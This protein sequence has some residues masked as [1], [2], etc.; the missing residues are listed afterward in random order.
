MK[1]RILIG[2]ALALV[3]IVVGWFE[4]FSQPESHRIANLQ[5]QEQVALGKVAQLDAQYVAL[6]HS[7]K[8]LPAERAAL[9][10]LSEAVPSG[11]EL[12]NLVKSLWAASNASGTQLTNISSP[13][14]MY[15]GAASAT[16]LSGPASIDLTISVNGTPAQVEALVNHLDSES[17]LFVLDSFSLSNPVASSAS[18]A[19]KTS[20]T[21]I[22][23]GSAISLRAF[24]ATASSDNPAS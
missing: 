15:F 6:V 19:A 9:G 23:G 13:Q 10:K 3:V 22:V 11:P 20:G 24:Y 4:G 1:R 2:A 18:G 17:R 7:E 14:P 12:D 8:E 5:Q 16:T 21:A